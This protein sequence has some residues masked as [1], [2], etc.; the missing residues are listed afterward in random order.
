[1]LWILLVVPI[2][3]LLWGAWPRPVKGGEG[4]SADER[5]PVV[6]GLPTAVL[7]F[8]TFNIHGGKGRDGMRDLSRIANDLATID[9]AALQEV[10]DS[11]QA[12]RQLHRLCEQLG[13]AALN[14][15]ARARWFRLHR[16][17]ALLTRHSLGHWTRVRLF[18]PPGWRSSCRNLTIVQM[19]QPSVHVLFTHLNRKT[20]RDEQLAQVMHMF[21]RYSPAVL[22]GDLNVRRDD[23]AIGKYLAR[24]DI[25]DALNE[26]LEDDDPAR[27]DW[28]LCRGLTVKNGG[29]ID[30]GASD[31]PLYWCDIEFGQE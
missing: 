20:G 3:L 19:K 17:N 9:V 24:D 1:M 28:V 15:P 12:K 4:C 16:N 23:P 2:G 10:H 31:H 6:S 18:D 13:L 21:L 30:S 22:M 29:V 5:V 11:W 14:A 8:G 7:R 27:I 25:T 26:I